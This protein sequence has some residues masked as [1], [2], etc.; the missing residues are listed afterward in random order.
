M[1]EQPKLEIRPGKADLIV[2]TLSW[3][4]LGFLWWIVL[5]KYSQLPDIIPT[6]YNLAGEVDNT[7]SKSSLFILPLIT[8]V[9]YIALTILNRYP[10]IFN[11]PGKITP[12][13]AYRQYANA[14]FLVRMVKLFI[15][16]TFSVISLFL[17]KDSLSNFS[18][19]NSILLILF[20]AIF[21]L[22]PIVI[23]II[24]YAHVNQY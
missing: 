3:A 11:Y 20:I 9:L 1:P 10:H 24:R 6:H 14:V 18:A 17:I 23:Y 13:N 8:T 4:V 21:P 16:V 7:G 5:S 19:S 2:E 15:G 22:V 12:E